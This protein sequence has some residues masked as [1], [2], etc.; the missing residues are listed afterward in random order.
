MLLKCNLKLL[1]QQFCSEKHHTS[2]L[3]QKV[4]PSDVQ[5]REP[6]SEN[7]A[8]NKDSANFQNY[9]IHSRLIGYI[10]TGQLCQ[11][12][13]NCATVNLVSSHLQNHFRHAQQTLQLGARL[14]R[15]SSSKTYGYTELWKRRQ[16]GAL[17]FRNFHW[18]IALWEQDNAIRHCK[19]HYHDLI[20]G[21]ICIY[22]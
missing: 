11:N 7:N 9:A 10:Q 15:T 16:T 6:A 4:T 5:H 13:Q 22:V 14:L 21:R 2:I 17:T 12:G 8:T 19:S 20:N 18:K 1:I 3:V